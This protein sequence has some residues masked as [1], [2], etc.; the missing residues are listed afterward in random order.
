MHREAPHAYGHEESS[1]QQERMN[2][3]G[4]REEQRSMKNK[5]SSQHAYGQLQR[6][7]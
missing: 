5:G 2:A 6:G 3:Q 7:T 1:G 4:S